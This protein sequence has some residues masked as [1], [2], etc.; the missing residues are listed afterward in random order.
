M[1]STQQVLILLKGFIDA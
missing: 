1:K